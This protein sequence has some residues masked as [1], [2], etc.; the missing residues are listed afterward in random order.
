MEDV[1][2][3][4]KK[5]LLRSPQNERGYPGITNSLDKKCLTASDGEN[6]ELSLDVIMVSEAEPMSEKSRINHEK[7]TDEPTKPITIF[8]NAT[9]D[10]EKNSDLDFKMMMK[11]E[12]EHLKDESKD[13]P[14]SIDCDDRKSSNDDFENH[15]EKTCIDSSNECGQCGHVFLVNTCMRNHMHWKHVKLRHK[16]IECDNKAITDSILKSHN[17]ID[18]NEVLYNTLLVETPLGKDNKD[19]QIHESNHNNNE[20]NSFENPPTEK[21]DETDF[22][23]SSNSNESMDD[24][25]ANN[26]DDS[27]EKGMFS[28]Y[29]HLKYDCHEC[30]RRVNSECSFFIHKTSNHYEAIHMK[31][32]IQCVECDYYLKLEK[33]M[34]SHIHRK[35]VRLK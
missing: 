5:H 18:H 25:F 7:E 16:C 26:P 11:T 13:D 3:N 33:E 9:A 24:K 27:D 35:H 10:E 14:V 29:V 20:D 19:D 2:N 34:L 22:D 30:E 4:E 8:E 21:P 31:N 28:K 6:P 17:K 1:I 23:S 12:V 15:N 32:V